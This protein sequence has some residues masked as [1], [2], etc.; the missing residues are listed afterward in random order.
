VASFVVDTAEDRVDC[1]ERAAAG[2]V[3]REC[4]KPL[5]THFL[6][7]AGLVEVG[8]GPERSD[9]RLCTADRADERQRGGRVDLLDLLDVLVRDETAAETGSHICRNDNAVL[10]RDTDCRRSGLVDGLLVTVAGGQ[11]TQFRLCRIDIESVGMLSNRKLRID[12]GFHYLPVPDTDVRNY[13]FR[14][15]SLLLS[16]R[17][18]V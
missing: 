3:T 6:A 13:S 14:K 8:L 15:V 2:E 9:E 5:H 1:Q 11:R 16:V 4:R 10:G 18:A 7:T 17:S 12:G